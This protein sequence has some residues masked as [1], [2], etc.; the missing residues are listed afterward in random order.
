[1]GIRYYAYAFDKDQT[2]QALVDPKA[3]I[4]RDPLADAWGFEPGARVATVSF[5]QAVPERDM[6]YLDKA[7]DWL[8]VATRP[9]SDDGSARPAFRLFEGAVTMRHDGWIPWYR[10]LA[11]A[12]VVDVADDLADLPDDRVAFTL[13]RAG[14]TNGDVAYALQYL[15]STRAFVHGL[16]RDGRG[17]AYMIG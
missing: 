5:E 3:F 17:L 16:V 2:D 8:Q 11:P 1:M 12:E 6:L 9:T 13:R 14:A 4:G 10:A 15:R 7:W